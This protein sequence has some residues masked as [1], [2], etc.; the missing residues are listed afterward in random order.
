MQH[1]GDQKIWN[2]EIPFLE[3]PPLQEDEMERYE[4][5]VVSEETG[6]LYEHCIRAIERSLRFGAHGLPL[7]GGGDWNDGMNLVGAGGSGESVWLGWFLYQVL[8][9]FIPFVSHRNETDRADEY[10]RIAEN[11]AASL[12]E[13]C[14][15]GQWFRRA[16]ND[17]GEPLGAMSNLE[18]QIDCIAQAWA[19]ISGAAD[20]DKALMAMASLDAQLV[21]RGDKSLVC[22]LTPPF[23]QSEPS[24]GYI[25]AYP[26]G[27]R[28]NGGQYTHGA[29]WAI[30]AWALLGKGNKAYEL[31]QIL[32]P[33][34]HSRTPGETQQY[35]VEPYVMAADVYSVPPYEGREAGLV[36]GAAGWMYQAGLGGSGNPQ[37]ERSFILSLAFPLIGRVFRGL[38]YGRSTYHL[39]IETPLIRA[40]EYALSSMVSC[41]PSRWGIPLVNDG[42]TH[43]VL[44]VL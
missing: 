29:I 15:D 10:E 26:R 12:N 28:E 11:L 9:E 13:Q 21:C 33:I 4:P 5:T 36:Y 44:L 19:V 31:F 18:C 8:K 40:G 16:Y 35:K 23:S 37:K 22:L 2:Q 39:Q 25:Q 3:S 24:P 43:Q 7:M 17:R 1:T 30:I 34:N 41:R 20:P 6:T 27:V 32:N 38:R 42:Q 14:W